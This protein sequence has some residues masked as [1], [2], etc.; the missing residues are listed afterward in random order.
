MRTHPPA[1]ILLGAALALRPPAAPAA[2][3]PVSL[4][5]EHAELLVHEPVRATV[6]LVNST[7]VPLQFGGAGANAALTFELERAPDTPLP[8]QR[9]GSVLTNHR[10]DPG[11][12]ESLTVVLNEWYAC[13]RAGRYYVR[14]LLQCPGG[15]HQSRLLMMDVVE[16]LELA[17][18]RAA[19]PGLP[20]TVRTY[21]LRYWP[22]EQ[23]ETL[24]LCVAE[25]PGSLRYAPI[26]L[27]RLLRSTAPTLTVEAGNRLR[28]RHQVTPHQFA[29][30]EL[31]SD[32]GG[33]RLADQRIVTEHATP[34]PPPPPPPPPQP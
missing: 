30:S 7:G 6:R 33:I 9:A 11:Q 2:D 18:A 25:E 10:L 29:Y 32:A 27:G 1:A 19:V 8:P 21:S 24:F 16:G 12:A 15:P 28:V 26:N 34:Q 14:A 20:G 4:Q 22:R 31:V 23:R 13:G 5:L 17:D 3:P